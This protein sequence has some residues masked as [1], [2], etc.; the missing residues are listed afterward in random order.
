M[1]FRFFLLALKRAGQFTAAAFAGLA[2]SW[3]WRRFLLLLGLIPLLLVFQSCNWL[4]F[5][6]DEL[7]FPGYRRVSV[8]KPLF[9]IGVP[10]SGTTLLQ[11]VLAADPRL[12]TLTTWEC[13]FAPSIVQ[14]RFWLALA[15]LDRRLGGPLQ[16]LV[17]ALERR[18][19]GRFD[20]IHVL[21]LNM[22]EEDY[23]TLLPVLSCFLL[24]LVVPEDRFLWRL[25]W[26]DRE[27]RNPDR[28]LI[29]GYY[30]AML[31]KHLYVRGTDKTL[32]AKNPAFCSWI[33]AL[34]ESF[35]GCRV[36]TP[37]R[38]P[39]ATYH[40]QL[41]SLRGGLNLLQLEQ[42]APQLAGQ[43]LDL[44]VHAYRVLFSQIPEQPDSDR[45]AV[46][47]AELK[48]NLLEGIEQLYQHLGL[49]MDETFRQHLTTEAG[50]AAAYRSSHSYDLDL[51]QLDRQQIQLAL[52]EAQQHFARRCSAP[53]SGT[54]NAP[55]TAGD[56][57]RDNLQQEIRAC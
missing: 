21:R 43:F 5:L 24:V 13:L 10:R 9:I 35:P 32:L 30:R 27:D 36:V 56:H 29:L 44:F 38:E 28:A 11:R 55:G 18:L 53:L 26:F 39:L 54:A 3:S 51:F 47:L 33:P 8:E 23:L 34:R 46:P 22:P 14:R 41:S 20:R 15:A 49:P 2:D 57:N 25:G 16:D 19:R 45:V 4:A 48:N 7:L 42:Q 40:S 17:T 12:T 52:E 50:L 31:Q 6:L 1:Q 37:L